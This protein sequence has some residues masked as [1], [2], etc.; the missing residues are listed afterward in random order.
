MRSNYNFG[1]YTRKQRNLLYMY[2]EMREQIQAF[3][4][5]DANCQMCAG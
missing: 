3:L 4:E 5:D 1:S 2:V